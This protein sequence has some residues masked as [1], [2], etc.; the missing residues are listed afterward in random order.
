MHMRAFWALLM[1]FLLSS[2]DRLAA[3]ELLDVGW[4]DPYFASY[5]NKTRSI[6]SMSGADRRAVLGSEVAFTL[7]VFGLSGVE[8]RSR[9]ANEWS[10][11][12]P[13][14][15]KLKTW[16]VC[17]SDNVSVTTIPE[18]ADQAAGAPLGSW[19]VRTFDFGCMEI[20]VEGDR[21][22]RDKAAAGSQRQSLSES[23]KIDIH[24]E[25]ENGDAKVDQDG[26]SV[27]SDALSA[28]PD[29]G[30]PVIAYSR[31]YLVY[32][33]TVVCSQPETKAFCNDRQSLETLVTEFNVVEG[34][35]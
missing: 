25:K 16:P 8:K 18:T 15:D 11:A 34:Q 27:P 20:I 3:Q 23:G 21:N 7:P 2:G 31:G 17:A 19:Y 14:R 5:R 10:I 6:Q 32:S 26:R 29:Q 13:L 33:F 24:Y 4:S 30:T 12:A 22:V 9:S 1:V 28:I 35:P